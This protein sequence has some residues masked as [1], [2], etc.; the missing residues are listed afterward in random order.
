VSTTI[1]SDLVPDIDIESAKDRLVDALTA[2]RDTAIAAVREDIAPAVAAAVGTAR[3]ASGPLYAEATSRAGDAASALRG[4]DAAKSLRK[5]KAAKA[6]QRKRNSR[7]KRIPIALGIVGLGA[8]AFAVIKRRSATPPAPLFTPPPTDAR[9]IP[10]AA[11]NGSSPTPTVV[12][13]DD[14]GVP[15]QSAAR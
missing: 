6:L 1:D 3:E 10:T 9:P 12:L 7:S 15:D 14:S 5:S 4:S 8:A 11:S 2:A 13:P